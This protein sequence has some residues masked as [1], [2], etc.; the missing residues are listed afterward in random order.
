MHLLQ[1]YHRMDLPDSSVRATRNRGTSIQMRVA[2]N[3][4][5]RIVEHRADYSD[6]RMICQRDVVGALAIPRCDVRAVKIYGRPREDDLTQFTPLLAEGDS[7]Q[8]LA[9]VRT[10]RVFHRNLEITV[11]RRGD[12][13]DTAGH[14]EPSAFVPCARRV[15]VQVPARTPPLAHVGRGKGHDLTAR[16]RSVGFGFV[17]VAV[18]S[19]AAGAGIENQ[20]SLTQGPARVGNKYGSDCNSQRTPKQNPAIVHAHA[21]GEVWVRGVGTGSRVEALST[22]GFDSFRYDMR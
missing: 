8:R 14:R 7:D 1:F 9:R 2:V 10:V 17:P 5:T 21:A 19:I 16:G 13:G 18:H 15:T 20:R 6:Q 22:L 12:R 3:R 4:L 11:S